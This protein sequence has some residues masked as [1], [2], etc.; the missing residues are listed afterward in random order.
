MPLDPGVA[1][2]V[3]KDYVRRVQGA[4]DDEPAAAG[5][6]TPRE[7]E[8]L[9]LVAEGHTNQAIADRLGLSRKTVD[10]HRTNLMR[11][12]DLH[13]VTELVKYALKRG[14]ISLE[15]KPGA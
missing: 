14:L 3:M 6:L 2:R 9:R 10:V 4:R 8:V 5:E 11:K 7:L 15:G 1:A 12:L 13:D